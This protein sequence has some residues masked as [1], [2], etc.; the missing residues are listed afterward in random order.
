M[1]KTINSAWIRD[2]R[3][4]EDKQKIYQEITNSHFLLDKLRK[5]CYN[6]SI[7]LEEV[8]IK[9]YDCPSWSHKQA[10]RNGQLE[11]LRKLEKILEVRDSVETEANAKPSRIRTE[12]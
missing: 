9:D 8:P 2:A 11:I 3:T 12:P 4:E 6:I 5:I 10:H 7:E 1:A